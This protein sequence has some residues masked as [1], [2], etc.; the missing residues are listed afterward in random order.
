MTAASD[1]T[2]RAEDGNMHLSVEDITLYVKGAP[3]YQLEIRN[4]PE[5]AEAKWSSD[6]PE[7]AAVDD[8]GLVTAV[9][10]GSAVITAS[11]GEQQLQCA[12]TV[13]SEAEVP[14]EDLSI[15][16]AADQGV[17]L[18]EDG[19]SVAEWKSQADADFKVAPS[20]KASAPKL[21][22]DDK[23]KMHIQFDGTDDYLKT[24]GVDFNNKSELTIVAV[25]EYTGE[26][27][28]SE[29]YGDAGSVLFVNESG[30]WGSVYLSPFYDWAAMRFGSG[31]TNCHVIYNRPER[32]EERT[33]TMAVKNGT[34]EMMYV[35]GT[36]V[37]EKTGQAGTT[38]NNGNELY[39]GT[40]ISNGTLYP[41]EGFIS[42]ILVYDR[43][44]TDEEAEELTVY[45]N[46]KYNTEDEEE[47]EE[48]VSK[49]TL[50][51]FLDSAK[52]LLT[53]GSVDGCV[54]SVRE[55]FEEAVAEGEAVMADEN[56]TREEVLNAA[57]KLMKAIHAAD[58][59]A[60]DKTDLEMAAELAY[61]I[62][63]EDYV[64]AGQQEFTD[65]LEA[66]ETVISDGNAMQAETDAAWERLVTAMENL[67]MKADKSVLE[68]LISE[69]EGL[70]LSRYTE[71][72]AAQFSLA[73][74]SAQA[75]FADNELSV[76]D[77]QAVN[78]AAAELRSARAALVPVSE[79]SGDEGQ[80]GDDVQDP[81]TG[82]QGSGDV[83]DTDDGNPGSGDDADQGGNADHNSSA[84]SVNKAAKT[85][86]E[87][88]AAG[89]LAALAL[90]AVCG[91]A[92]VT[93]V[94]K[95]ER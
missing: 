30:S 9:S 89:L 91:T 43:A 50:E 38:A 14:V 18:A 13:K 39:I 58:M 2:V 21:V 66:A 19:T 41:Y 95:K 92:A 56:A 22:T 77:Q 82:S 76:D 44:L 32:M 12:V 65:A 1:Y 15:W 70:D 40:G 87:T 79:G 20:S 73:L 85:G 51:F 72:S 68:D 25:S 27:R 61:M 8:S 33:V 28:G 59:K 17:T 10:E 37:L 80:G 90:A 74:A 57:F 23:G 35:D 48:A 16:L 42:E 78:S 60:A 64:T 47:P 26:E 88:P 24:E 81:D 11:V 86:D 6:D 55:L 75:V 94:R 83:Q 53:D 63:L 84:A 31:V 71:E 36:K 34:A 69:A 54:Q 3:Q 46:A 29:Q 5:G 52:A 7:V 4:L 62:D 67:R 45:L 49:K 93:T